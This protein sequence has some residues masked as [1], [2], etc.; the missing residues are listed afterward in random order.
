MIERRHHLTDGS[1]FRQL[2]LTV[3][4]VLIVALTSPQ[5]DATRFIGVAVVVERHEI[6]NVYPVLL[7]LS[8][9]LVDRVG[10]HLLQ[11]ILEAYL[12]RA[13]LLRERLSFLIATHIRCS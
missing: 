4:I 1:L 9:G 11:S 8:L 3:F 13:L 7:M 5:L 6:C 10:A 2:V 12:F